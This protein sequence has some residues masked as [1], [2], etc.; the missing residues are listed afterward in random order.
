MVESE[1]EAL[2]ATARTTSEA[3]EQERL[4]PGSD[5]DESMR[6]EMTYGESGVRGANAWI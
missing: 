1:F 3:S 2:S 4:T 6:N 5:P